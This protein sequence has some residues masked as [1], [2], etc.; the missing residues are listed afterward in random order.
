MAQKRLNSLAMLYDNKSILDD[1]KL[2]IYHYLMYRMNSADHV[3]HC[4]DQKN[5]FGSFTAKDLYIF[6]CILFLISSYFF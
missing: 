1:I 5:T 6:V 4:P 2:M 3:D